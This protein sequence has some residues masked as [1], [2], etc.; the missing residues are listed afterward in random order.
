MTLSSVSVW[1]RNASENNGFSDPSSMNLWLYAADVNNKP[2]GSPLL[3]L[4]TGYGLVAWADE[5]PV[6]RGSFA[7]RC[8]GLRPL[9]QAH[10]C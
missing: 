7:R 9:A 3:T 1:V 4:F 8:G 2:S 5:K 6:A 10:H